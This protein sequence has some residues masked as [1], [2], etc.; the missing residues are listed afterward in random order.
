MN[1]KLALLYTLQQL[2]S[3]IDVL[4][5]QFAA[6]DA[7][8][9]EKATL[10]AGRALHHQASEALRAAGAS[11]TDAELEQKAVET[12]RQ[13]EE[14]KL[15]SGKVTN[16]KELQAIQDEVEMLQRQKIRLDEKLVTILEEVEISQKRETETK[17]TES[18]A[19][20]ANRSKVQRY[21]Q[22][23]GRI[24]EQAR[25]LSAQRTEAQAAVP[26]D[27]RKRY[28]AIRANKGGIGI[29]KVED[30][31]AC[32]GCKMGLPSSLVKRIQE[33]RGLETCENCGRILWSG[34]A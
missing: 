8:A 31:N 33:G 14:T 1:D 26:P 25:V 19:Q 2:D 10:E 9:S 4:K 18:E 34:K 17:Q 27:L 7:G 16:P 22:E 15:Y 11:K 24:A 12:K 28:E 13:L 32:G 21:K 23:A 5:K 6:L 29:V 20:S 30:A 3:A